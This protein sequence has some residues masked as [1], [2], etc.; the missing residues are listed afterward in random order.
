[1]D[2]PSVNRQTGEPVKPTKKEAGEI[3]SL[4]PLN[5]TRNPKLEPRT[6]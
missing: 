5:Q 1:M 6:P 3:L 4:Q 2:P